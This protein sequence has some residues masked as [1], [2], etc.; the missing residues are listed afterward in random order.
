MRRYGYVVIGIDNQPIKDY[1][2]IPDCVSTCVEGYIM[3]SIERDDPRI[4]HQDFRVRMLPLTSNTKG[5][6]VS[7][8]S[9]N[10]LS[11]RMRRFRNK[12]CLFIWGVKRDGSDNDRAYMN[13]ILPNQFKAVNSTR[14]FRDLFEHELV[15]REM[16]SFG[17]NVSRAGNRQLSAGE[18]QKAYKKLEAKYQNLL[19]KHSKAQGLIGVSHETALKETEDQAYDSDS[20]EVVASL[21]EH[22]GRKRRRPAFD[23]QTADKADSKEAN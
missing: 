22:P 8:P 1:P 19:R 12:A 21:P 15:Y 9:P 23:D 17:H 11:A 18:W 20:E 4:I 16:Q 13:N 14:G 10:T 6:Q 5:Q 2:N 3:E 7:P